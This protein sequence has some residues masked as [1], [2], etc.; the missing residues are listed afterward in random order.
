MPAP[1]EGWRPDDAVD[2]RPP[3]GPHPAA[4][5]RAAGGRGPA[6]R[7]LP[8]RGGRRLRGRRPPPGVAPGRER[9]RVRRPGRGPTGAHGAPPGRA[10]RHPRPG[11][12]RAGPLRAPAHDLGRPHRG[13][14]PRRRRRGAGP[15]P[16]HAPPGARRPAAP[17]G[18]LHV[19]D[20]PA[21]AGG[22]L[23]G[24]S[25]YEEPKRFLPAGR[26]GRSLLGAVDLDGRG[27]SGL[28]RQYEDV[29]AGRPGRL[30][31]ERAI[32]GR[33]IPAG[34]NRLEPPER[35]QDL[36][37]TIDRDLQYAVEQALSAQVQ[38]THAE[39][40][41]VVVMDPRNGEVL[42]MASVHADP[43]GTPPKQTSMNTALQSVFEP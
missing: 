12:H 37:L 9:R 25:S 20:P 38:S 41:T 5:H 23:P 32:D 30:L 11:R 42:S 4:A 14:R 10:G 27:R 7:G 15:D 39:G 28:E 24:I 2:R 1:S 34:N 18:P 21:H 6:L 31:V 43:P 33:T 35:G 8:G 3:T 36:V 29:L 19:P 26:L 40:G 17:R 22:G 13:G 16:R